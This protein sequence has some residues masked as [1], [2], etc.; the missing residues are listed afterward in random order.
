MNDPQILDD[1]F[2][3]NPIRFPRDKRHRVRAFRY[4]IYALILSVVWVYLD[5][6][7]FDNYSPLTTPESDNKN[8]LIGLAATR[9]AQ[10]FYI[11][12]GIFFLAKSISANERN[13]GFKIG[14]MVGFA[15][16][17]LQTASYYLKYYLLNR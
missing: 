12:F 7:Y 17:I 1:A 16:L 2:E 13:D 11:V 14:S 15:L 8:A 4:F 3:R 5:V 9:L 6:S 10:L